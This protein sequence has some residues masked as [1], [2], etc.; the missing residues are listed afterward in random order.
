MSIFKRL[1]PNEITI[2]PFKAHKK[3]APTVDIE[4]SSSGIVITE[5]VN[6]TGHFYT[7]EEKNTNGMYKRSVYH[8]VNK[9]HYAYELDP[10]QTLTNNT[11]E[12]LEK[13]YI[14]TAEDCP[15]PTHTSASITHI[16][17][18]QKKFGERIKPGTV[19]ITSKNDEVSP[20][21]NGEIF[22]DDSLGNLY[23]NTISSSW[24][25]SNSQSYWPPT[26]SL[27]GY[28]KFD[29]STDPYIDYSGNGNRAEH[30]GSDWTT[31]YDT[32][33]SA[34]NLEGLSIKTPETSSGIRLMRHKKLLDQNKQ[35]WTLWF[36]PTGHTNGNLGAR[37]ITRDLSEYFG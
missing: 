14:T 26:G 31:Y 15:F 37:I 18:P 3:F 5:G 28:W 22:Y 20:S 35:T 34:S 23:S 7:A 25:S 12:V 21:L 2:T 1:Q 33:I 4:D 17:I 32:D 13:N 36:K 11:R 30:T 29:N 6:Y 27:K 16:L 10:A 8:L 24:V 9:L 19:K